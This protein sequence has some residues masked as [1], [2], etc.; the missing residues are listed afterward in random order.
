MNNRAFLIL[1]LVIVT[2]S[3]VILQAQA[4]AYLPQVA[5]GTDPAGS[6]R[7]T[8]VL[9]N[10][11]DT[12][13]T[14]TIRLTNDTGG[15][16]S[17][18]IPGQGTGAQFGPLALQPGQTIFLQTDGFG[19]LTVGAA[20]VQSSIP[21]GVS[22]IFTLFGAAQNF[23]TEAGVGNSPPLDQFVIPVDSTGLFNTGVALF[24]FNNTDTT[25]TYKLVELNGNQVATAGNPKTELLP[26]GNH[27]A[28][29]FSGA[30]SL[31]PSVSNF[32]GTLVVT[33]SQPIAAVTLRQNGV[34]LSNTTLPVVS[35]AGQQTSFN[36]P[37]VANGFDA[38]SGL[39]MRTTFVAVNI[40]GGAVMV[41]FTL[42]K[43]DGTPFPV[44]IPGVANNAA[45]FSTNLPAGGS[46]FLQTD[47]SGTLSAGSAEV[48]SDGPV[49]V[50]GIFTLYG[51]G[52][53]FM[54]EAGVGDSPA[55]MT[56]TLPVDITGNSTTGVALFNPNA[57]PATVLIG[58]FN[59]SGVKVADA[60]PLV[61]GAKGQQAKFVGELFTGQTSF[62]GSMGITASAG[63]AAMTIRE[64]GAPITYT[65]LPVVDGVSQGNTG[66]P[67]AAL[68]DKTQANVDATANTTVNA[69]LQAGFKLSG[70]VTGAQLVASVVAQN[71]TG[72]QFAAAYSVMTSRYLVVVPAGSYT[73]RVCY[74]PQTGSSQSSSSI[75]FADPTAVQVN[76]DTTRNITIP[77]LTLN[78]VSGTVSGVAQLPTN[79]GLALNFSTADGTSGGTAVVSGT[80]AYE[81]LLPNGTYTVSLQVSNVTAPPATPQLLMTLYSIGTV[82]VTGA[83]V[84]ANLDPPA[85][86]NVS[87]VARRA[88]T[89][90]MPPTA[91]VSAID[92]SGPTQQAAFT[93]NF[94]A[95]ASVT[96]VNPSGDFDVQRA[97]QLILATGRSY[98]LSL[99]FPV[100]TSGAVSFPTDGRL[101]GPLTVNLAQN[102]DV[103]A[104]P[105]NV[106]VSGKVTDP[107]GQPVSGVSVT[108]Q[109]SQIT[110]AANV[111][112]S[113]VATTDATGNYS[114]TV[115]NGTAYQLT[116]VPP[117]PQP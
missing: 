28:R 49:G 43:S 38:A 73:L 33:S 110:G 88:G 85:R 59:A 2:L 89:D 65:T 113:T 10:P 74:V 19:P 50:A 100:G 106:T 81:I 47:G 41:N 32:R 22:A 36:L 14:A 5:N 46:A 72:G 26:V 107:Q 56:A 64:N 101:I 79:S 78:R 69:G 87:G 17:V 76:A 111:T 9:F 116:F 7:T 12:V 67:T 99:T 92:T 102:L 44:T 53:S 51:A 96:N 91:L 39:S 25:V 1:S 52:P 34:P 77:A 6:M 94:P 61:I 48:T 108:A 55:K 13:A 109:S 16:L 30:N 21:L 82:T 86:A 37:Q 95:T 57:S 62:R 45:S 105:G 104:L 103:P 15:D 112:F 98:R 117:K 58:L 75:S 80:G 70:T 8:F 63:I 93:C 66:S 40:S 68:L 115:L 84:T 71:S 31:F 29:F 114:L 3:V 90:G 4:E 20:R 23:L 18:T 24:N 97:Y 35:S 11:T 60:T 54:T 27:V 83:P 42:R